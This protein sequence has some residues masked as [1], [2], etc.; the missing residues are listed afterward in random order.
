MYCGDLESFT[1][2][3][4]PLSTFPALIIHI[5]TTKKSVL[6]FYEYIFLNRKFEPCSMQQPG[7]NYKEE[8]S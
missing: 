4:L 8:L 6:Y 5:S 7:K 3:K 1:H 2:M